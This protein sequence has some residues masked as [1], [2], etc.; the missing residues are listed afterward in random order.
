[1]DLDDPHRCRYC[2][3]NLHPVRP[4]EC[5][6]EDVKAVVDAE[7]ERWDRTRL[8]A[9]ELIGRLD[10]MMP[11]VEG[12]VGVQSLRQGSP[13]YDG[14]DPH[15]WIEKLREHCR[16]TGKPKMT[17]RDFWPHDYCK[18]CEGSGMVMPGEGVVPQG[19]YLDLCVRSV[20]DRAAA[21][22]LLRGLDSQLKATGARALLDEMEGGTPLP[23]LRRGKTWHEAWDVHAWTE[24]GAE[25]AY[26]RRIVWPCYDICPECDGTANRG[27]PEGCPFEFNS[28]WPE[29]P[30]ELV[31]HE[32][33][34]D[35]EM[36]VMPR[37][38]L[39]RLFRVF[40]R[41]EKD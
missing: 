21:Y 24:I 6:L 38:E 27:L 3:V 2:G 22:R 41:K 26:R 4:H 39:E 34:V 23:V 8:L 31:M 33:N 14:P 40:S 35:G 28:L 11:K 13:A 12:V 10:V 20:P 17:E 29:A 37:E 1:M 18:A 9:L 16:L 32:R 15:P 7:Q 5:R 25:F 30:V 36:Q 19:A